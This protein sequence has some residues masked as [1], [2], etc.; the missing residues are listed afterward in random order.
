VSE[1]G[2]GGGLGG[3]H[4]GREERKEVAPKRSRMREIGVRD[5]WK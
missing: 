4:E 3:R 5:H 2:V 1:D